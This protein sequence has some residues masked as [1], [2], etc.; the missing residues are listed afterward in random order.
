MSHK[1]QSINKVD[2]A[3]LEHVG[4]C[5]DRSSS[6]VL[7]FTDVYIFN[8]SFAIPDTLFFF[9]FFFTSVCYWYQCLKERLPL[10]IVSY[11]LYQFQEISFSSFFCIA[12]CQCLPLARLCA[13]TKGRWWPWWGHETSVATLVARDGER[14]WCCPQDRWVGSH[15]LLPPDLSHSPTHINTLSSICQSTGMTSVWFQSIMILW[16]SSAEAFLK[17]AGSS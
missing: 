2:F 14:K 4:S 16:L 6:C 12:S 17:A 15:V 5:W 8:F 13:S 11:L 9:F 3:L 10:L 7:I 1:N